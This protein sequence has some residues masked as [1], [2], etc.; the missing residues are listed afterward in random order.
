[1]KVINARMDTYYASAFEVD[2]DWPC[3][4]CIDEEMIVLKYD[5]EHGRLTYRGHSD[6]AGH[7]HLQADGFQGK[8]TLHR[9]PGG[10]TLEGYWCEEGKRGMWFISFVDD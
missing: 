3:E 8:G 2:T 6:G 10:R 5:G 7:Y 4:V 9:F 1:M